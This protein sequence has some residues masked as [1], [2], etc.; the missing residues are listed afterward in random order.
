MKKIGALLFL[1]MT[2]ACTINSGEEKFVNPIFY[3]VMSPVSSRA[4]YT[5]ITPTEM[6]SSN[7]KGDTIYQ[8]CTLIEN[9]MD[10]V[11]LRCII[12]Y[13]DTLIKS[14]E[15]NPKPEDYIDIY[16]FVLERDDKDLN[17]LIVGMYD[18]TPPLI[19][20]YH[21]YSALIIRNN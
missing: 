7:N 5:Q 8:A 21:S 18:I 13:P 6:I 10:V 12:P 1:L 16:R 19:N 11:T 3:K 17:G 20:N 9:T 4:W 15:R 14:L 2:V